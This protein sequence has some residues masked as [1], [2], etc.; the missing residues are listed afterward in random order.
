MV[1]TA[2][3]K[4]LV[5][6]IIPSYNCRKFLLEAY[7]SVLKQTYQNI[8]II[9]VDDNSS[10]PESLEILRAI[11]KQGRARIFYLEKNHGVAYARNFAIKNSKGKYVLPLDCDD[12]IHEEYLEKAVNILDKN[13]EIKI[14]YP[15]VIIFGKYDDIWNL[16]GF[17][18][19]KLLIK[20][21]IHNSSVFR[22][23][24]FARTNGYDERLE[25]LEDWDFWISILETTNG[26]A[27]H[28]PEK[29]FYYR[30]RENSR[31]QNLNKNPQVLE[32]IRKQIVYKHLKFYCEILG[33]PRNLYLENLNLKQKIARIENSFRYKLINSIFK[34]YDLVKKLLQ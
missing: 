13:E 3:N 18:L 27:L 34:P 4:T 9:I 5:S 33:E 23:S 24:D 20:N 14:V 8:E 21:Y 19:K 31:Q 6:V 1:K 12:K 30:I 2:T 15:D 17:D 29:L 11:E 32:N 16:P 28:L 7:E 26:K 25:G 10:D 22:K